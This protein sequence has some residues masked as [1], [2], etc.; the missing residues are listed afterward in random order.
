MRLVVKVDK[1]THLDLSNNKLKNEFA[2]D[3]LTLL[4]ANIST[5]TFNLSGNPI[6]FRK[7]QAINTALEKNKNLIRQNQMP[8]YRAE[9]FRLREALKNANKVSSGIRAVAEQCKKEKEGAEVLQEFFENVQKTKVMARITVQRKLQD[10][11]KELHKA[12]QALYHFNAQF[13]AERQTQQELLEAIE[14]KDEAVNE[15][16]KILS[17]ARNFS[18]LRVVDKMRENAREVRGRRA[19]KKFEL[20]KQLESEKLR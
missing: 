13:E 5:F 4:K 14:G 8:G 20:T 7:I 3:A 11:T 16:I 19:K 15:Q 1:V 2:T 9:I 12:N 6:G 17:N 10:L 18:A